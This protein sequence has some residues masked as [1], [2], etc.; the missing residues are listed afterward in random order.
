MD[1]G[2]NWRMEEDSEKR[3][4]RLAQHLSRAV[5]CEVRFAESKLA[6]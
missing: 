3:I 5:S 1:L 2:W 4:C 6:G